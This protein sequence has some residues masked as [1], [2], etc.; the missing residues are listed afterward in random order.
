MWFMCGDATNACSMLHGRV[1]DSHG[2]GWFA[3]MSVDNRIGELR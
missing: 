1:A 2:C 3:E